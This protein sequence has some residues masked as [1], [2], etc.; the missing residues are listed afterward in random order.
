MQQPPHHAPG[1]LRIDS[2][3]PEAVVVML[4]LIQHSL[5][6][7]FTSHGFG[8]LGNDVLLP[9]FTFSGGVL[10]FLQP[11]AGGVKG[12]SGD[13]E[14]LWVGGVGDVKVE[15]SG[16][17]AGRELQRGDVVTD[18]GRGRGERRTA[19]PFGKQVR[20]SEEGN[21]KMQHKKNKSISQS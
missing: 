21:R 16:S 5:T 4:Q 20:A 7:G 3:Q 14:G 17:T 6:H 1:D 19:M 2:Q 9:L 10:H 8:G 15:G 18:T 11:G 13:A 12:P